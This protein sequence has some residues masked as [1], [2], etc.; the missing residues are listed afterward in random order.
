MTKTQNS[1][2][3]TALRSPVT[4]Q[5]APRNPIPPQ[6]IPPLD[7]P[8]VTMKTHVHS[9]CSQSDFGKPRY[10]E[11]QSESSRQRPLQSALREKAPLPKTPFQPTT[12]QPRV[13]QQA[14]FQ[15]IAPQPIALKKITLKKITP[16]KIPA[17]A[18][19]KQTL[20]RVAPQK[21][22]ASQQGLRV[23]LP[24]QALSVGTKRLSP[25]KTKC[26][27]EPSAASSAVA[28]DPSALSAPLSFQGQAEPMP[29]L[30]ECRLPLQGQQ[31]TFAPVSAAQRPVVTRTS[32]VVHHASD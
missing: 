4:F 32:L 10:C 25:L 18:F 23:S 5:G 24:L 8:R 28:F 20:R 6:G 30:S 14:T 26:A 16:K 3:N 19:K 9:S 13:F 7:I 2:L 21:Q 27:S 31:T 15:Q 17:F 29:L 11:P 12:P 1:L 22:Q